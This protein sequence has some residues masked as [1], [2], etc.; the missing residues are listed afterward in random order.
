MPQGDSHDAFRTAVR[1]FGMQSR[2]ADSAFGGFVD[3]AAAA[4]RHATSAAVFQRGHGLLPRRNSRLH[5]ERTKRGSDI[6]FQ[7]G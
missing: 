3:T 2:P 7:S 1:I 4:G 5:P 6:P